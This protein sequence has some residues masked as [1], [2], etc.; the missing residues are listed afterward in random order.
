[1]PDHA[2]ERLFS[3]RSVAVAGASANPSKQGY[4]YLKH[5]L[6]Y[7]F[8]GSIFAVNPGESE[9]LG[10]QSY[11]SVAVLPEAPDLVI[12]TIPAEAVPQLLE[13]CGRRGVKFL[14]L[15][16]AMLGETG[17]PERKALEDSIISRAKGLGIRVLGPNCMGIYNP[18][19]GLTFRSVSSR[20]SGSVGFF[21]QSAAHAAEVMQRGWARGLAYSKA[22]SYGNAADINEC[23]IID[24]FSA[25]PETRVIVGYIEGIKGRN[26]TLVLKKAA[27]R[28]PVIIFKVGRTPAGA[29]A[30]ASHT[31]SLAGSYQ[32]WQGMMNQC[33]AVTADSIG[34]LID[35][36]IAFSKLTPPE[37]RNVMA[38]GAGG[39]GSIVAAEE[40]ENN[41]LVVPPFP[42]DT[43]KRLKGLLGNNWYLMKNPIDASIVAESGIGYDS[44]CG[45]MK[46]ADAHP[47]FNILCWDL[48]EWRPNGPEEAGLYR[49]M[50]DMLIRSYRSASKPLAAILRPGDHTEE[51]KWRLAM[52]TQQKCV[53]AGLAVFPSISRAAVA[54]GKLAD[55]H[56][57]IAKK[58]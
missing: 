13:D 6:D 25:D 24:Y 29:R 7:G 55:Y 23:E 4:R 39:G 40:F 28:K 22:V 33:G 54:L 49:S 47:F 58:S 9:I 15:F 8:T 36:G 10:V 32:V 53:E 12:S 1:M 3:P 48:G 37:G 16:A 14:H 42:P 41:G 19:C 52:E 45:M 38:V 2:L 30:A 20:R 34:G 11:P 43:T 18:A 56:L 50:T 51:W 5:L 31:G 26:F 44:I 17:V 35:A 46:L 21:S 57:R 27:A